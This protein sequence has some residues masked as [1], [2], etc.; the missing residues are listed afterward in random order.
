MGDQV[1]LEEDV[2]SSSKT[3]TKRI[4]SV[5]SSAALAASCF[6]AAGAS[7]PAMT[8]SALEAG[9]VANP[10]IWADVP[11]PDIIR[12]GDTYYMVSTTM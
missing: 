6:A 11:D 4:L 5:L 3:I 10:V 2:M 12:V 1:R 8:A 7:I 9:Q